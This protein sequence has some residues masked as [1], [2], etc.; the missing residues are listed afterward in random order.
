MDSDIDMG[1]FSLIKQMVLGNAECNPC[2]DAAADGD[3]D[4]ADFGR[5]KQIVL[6]NEVALTRYEEGY[7]FNSSAAGTDHIAKWQN[8]DSLPS[9]I[10]INETGWTDFTTVNY[11]QVEAI[12]TADFA[13]SGKPGNHSAV[14]CRFKIGEHINVSTVSDLHVSLV[15]SSEDT[16]ESL[17][18]WAW[19]YNTSSWS[20]VGGDMT[21]SDGENTYARHSVCDA[22]GRAFDDYIDDDRYMYILYF[23]DTLDK[24]LNVD[25]CEIVLSYP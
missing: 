17:Q 3:V 23:V 19:N 8:I 18:F 10:F 20:Q 5:V 1:D 12:D 9:D 24:D 7:D 11:T 21:M 14:E 6:L 2:G 22:W 25:Y 16:G 15:G 13:V 4:A